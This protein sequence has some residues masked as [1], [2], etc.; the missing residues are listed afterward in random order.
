MSVKPPTSP[1]A[2]KRA[3][4]TVEDADAEIDALLAKIPDKYRTAAAAKQQTRKR[5]GG[6]SWKCEPLT[7]L[8]GF[9]LVIGIAVLVFLSMSPKPFWAFQELHGVWMAEPQSAAARRVA[10]DALDEEFSITC[11]APAVVRTL[12][13]S[14]QEPGV[15]PTKEVTD[16]ESDKLVGTL[17]EAA[18]QFT[19]GPFRVAT[20]RMVFQP[21]KANTA[22]WSWT[23]PCVDGG[24]MMCTIMIHR[25]HT[26]FVVHDD[27][28]SAVYSYL[29]TRWDARRLG[30]NDGLM[31]F[32]KEKGRFVILIIGLI[33]G[34]KFLQY[35]L[36]PKEDV[37]KKLREQRFR[38]ALELRQ[39]ALRDGRNDRAAL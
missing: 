27:K 19:F 16:E 9:I 17:P 10:A 7:L 18:C 13:T 26:I 3:P 1:P 34:L 36:S 6:A 33:I 5:G 11:A 39:K 32:W 38:K 31:G 28:T 15:D 8:V 35:I 4:Q 30:G 12:L 21:I 14:E 22:V 29:L 2:T 24:D 25:K 23:G 37:G 20:T